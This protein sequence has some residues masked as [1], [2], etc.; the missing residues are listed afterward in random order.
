MLTPLHCCSKGTVVSTPVTRSSWKRQHCA[1][2]LLEAWDH[3]LIACTGLRCITSLCLFIKK[4]Q[5]FSINFEAFFEA[6]FCAFFRY[7]QYVTIR[8]FKKPDIIKRYINTSCERS[9]M[10]FYLFF[11]LWKL[12]SAFPGKYN[13]FGRAVWNKPIRETQPSQHMSPLNSHINAYWFS[14]ATSFKPISKNKRGKR[15]PNNNSAV[16]ILHSPWHILLPKT[17][18]FIVCSD[19]F[20]SCRV[21]NALQHAKKGITFGKIYCHSCRRTEGYTGSY[22]GGLEIQKTVSLW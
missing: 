10:E 12:S 3:I 8:S 15:K 19:A 11:H 14:S 20:Q 21:V 9:R 1:H 2:D 18:T 17:G 22:P 13:L 16:A 7:D 6:D 4:Q 5:S